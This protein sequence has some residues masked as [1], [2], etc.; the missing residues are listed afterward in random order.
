[1]R[2]L[3]AA[4]ASFAGITWSPVF[5]PERLEADK[6]PLNAPVLPHRP[7]EIVKLVVEALV[8]V[9]LVAQKFVKVAL[10]VE[11]LLKRELPDTIKLPPKY[12]LP[13]E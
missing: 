11:E 6:A 5:V 10:V 2:K 4:P 7:F 1:M 9:P 3:F 13:E 8:I 12:T